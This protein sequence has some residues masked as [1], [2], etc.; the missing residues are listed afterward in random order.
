MNNEKDSS[1]EHT[2]EVSS[3]V[4]SDSD[5]GSKQTN[6]QSEKGS[7]P[8]WNFVHSIGVLWPEPDQD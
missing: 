7:V 2:E 6:N 5:T 3:P 4:P 1:G 8:L